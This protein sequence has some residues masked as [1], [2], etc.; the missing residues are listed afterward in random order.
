M[1][2]TDDFL[3]YLYHSAVAKFRSKYPNEEPF[4]KI[5][6]LRRLGR[7]DA[8]HN[9][10]ET[11]YISY[12]HNKT[13][14]E[15]NKETPFIEKKYK[16]VERTTTKKIKRKHND[17]D[18]IVLRRSTQATGVSYDNII[19][20]ETKR[21]EIKESEDMDVDVEIIDDV[22]DKEIHFIKVNTK[23]E[24]FE[25]DSILSLEPHHDKVII[26]NKTSDDE[27]YISDILKKSLTSEEEIKQLKDNVS[28][29]KQ[30]LLEEQQKMSK[31][32]DEINE[33]RTYKVNEDENVKLSDK[34]KKAFS[35]N[36][37]IATIVDK[38]IELQTKLNKL[39]KLVDPYVKPLGP[40]FKQNYYKSLKDNGFLLSTVFLIKHYHDICDSDE[41]IEDYGDFE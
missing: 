37:P 33:K 8:N 6:C 18:E 26:H 38:Y 14:I 23:F 3:L 39:K 35:E 22:L 17:T 40:T 10:R 15:L 27:T 32:L 12:K 20:V 19:S 2:V 30:T 28:I 31:I 25:Q 36:I 7:A 29:T 4:I 34:I 21:V 9:W 1:R 11:K 13:E 5:Q 24:R 16:N 41:E